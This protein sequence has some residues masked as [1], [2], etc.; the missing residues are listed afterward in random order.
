MLHITEDN[1]NHVSRHVTSNVVGVKTR[2]KNKSVS[3]HCLDLFEKI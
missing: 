1:V 2:K 3:I